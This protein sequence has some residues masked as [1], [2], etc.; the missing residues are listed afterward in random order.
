MCN[1]SKKVTLSECDRLREYAND[2]LKRFFIYHISDKKGLMVAYVPKDRN[3]NDI[4][5]ERGFI[6]TDG[7]VEWYN[8]NEHPCIRDYEQN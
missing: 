1:C 8:V 4:A 3:P 7:N 2:K 5:L 6:G